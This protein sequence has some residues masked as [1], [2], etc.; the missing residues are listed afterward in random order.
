MER[1]RND[2][3][4]WVYNVG[5]VNSGGKYRPGIGWTATSPSNAPSARYDHSA[6]WTGSEMIVWGGYGHYEIKLTPNACIVL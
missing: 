4:G 5:Y 3:L 6:V 2:H 1:Q